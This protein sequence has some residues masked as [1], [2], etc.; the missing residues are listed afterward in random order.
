M[1][2]SGASLLISSW[3][4]VFFFTTTASFAQKPAKNPVEAAPQQSGMGGISSAGSFAPMYDEHRRPITAGGFVDKGTT[5]F[6]DV[7]KSSGL[8]SWRHVM[9]TPQKK[10]I[11]ETDGSGV[12]LIDYD[13]DGWLDIYLVNGSTYD[14]LDGKEDS[15][16]RGTLPQQSRRHIYRCGGKSRRHQR[17]LGIRRGHCRLRQRRLA[18]H[19]CCNCGKNR[20]YHNNH[21]GTFTDVAEKAGVTLGNW[22]RRRNMGR[23]QRRRTARSVRIGLRALRSEQSARCGRRAAWRSPSAR[24]AASR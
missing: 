24:C 16:A 23:L 22:S 18:R 4:A 7:S 11:I 21:D 5:V 2:R 10:Y 12:G 15:A 3:L 13:N 9:G 20:L 17:P 6:K 14:A 19:L 8:A 1:D